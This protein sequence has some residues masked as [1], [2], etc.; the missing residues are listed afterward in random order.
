MKWFSL[1][2]HDCYNKIVDH[3]IAWENLCLK[4]DFSNA[5]HP[6]FGM[7]TKLAF[8]ACLDVEHIWCAQKGWTLRVD[9]I[10]CETRVEPES[11]NQNPEL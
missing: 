5:R 8:F 6:G 2:Q 10:N 3:S 1:A 9:F 11:L 4:N 7:A